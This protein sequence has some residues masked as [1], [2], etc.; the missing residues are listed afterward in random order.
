MHFPLLS[1]F[2]AEWFPATTAAELTHP[3]AVIF[4]LEFLHTATHMPLFSHF[5]GHK[6]SQLN[7][8]KSNFSG[9]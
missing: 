8:E 6:S 1:N 2:I 7:I 3:L 5:L 4:T 9:I